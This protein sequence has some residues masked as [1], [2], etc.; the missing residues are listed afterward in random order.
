MPLRWRD[1]CANSRWLVDRF[2][3]IFV[4]ISKLQNCDIY[5]WE[6]RELSFSFFK[7]FVYLNFPR[8]LIAQ[9]IVLYILFNDKIY[10]SVMNNREISSSFLSRFATT[11]FHVI[12]VFQTG[13]KTRNKPI[14]YS[15][16]FPWVIGDSSSINSAILSPRR[17]IY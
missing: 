16:C 7:Y 15:N 2:Q 6:P 8:S 10:N 17:R 3:A 1:K 9:L 11:R 14:D 12:P 13:R 5:I 4:R